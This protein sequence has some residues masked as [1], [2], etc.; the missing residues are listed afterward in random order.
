MFLHKYKS[1]FMK[2]KKKGKNNNKYWSVVGDKDRHS[3]S[4][5]AA[6]TNI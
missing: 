6:M 3:D 5:Y 1:V 2:V 4:S